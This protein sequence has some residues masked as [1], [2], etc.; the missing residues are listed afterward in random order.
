MPLDTARGITNLRSLTKIFDLGV[1]AAMPFYPEIA[2]VV[3]SEGADEQYG[4]LGSVP[5]VREWLGDRQFHTLRG[6]QFTITNR[7]WENSVQIQKNDIDDGRLAKYGP[8]LEQMGIE[9]MHHP[10]ELM[11]ELLV[12]GDSTL[13]FDGQFFF[14]TDHSW[15]ASGTQSNDLTHAAATGTTPTEAE[16]RA[17]YHAARAALL[18]FRRDNG[19]LWHRPTI[20]PLTDLMLIVPPSLEEVA[21]AALYKTLVNSGESNIVLDRPRIVPVAYISGDKYYLLRTGQPIKPFIFQARRPLNRQMKGLDD[22][23]WK[24]VKFMTDA[25]YN[26]GYLGWWNAVLMTFT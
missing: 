18:G 10:D 16:F 2:T 12:A 3:Q 26:A 8:I 21:N 17:S 20:K 4:G 11:F 23:E 9:A 25:R 6:G 5:G 24:D 14:D 13:A 15:G 22:R 19:K 1:E 7:E